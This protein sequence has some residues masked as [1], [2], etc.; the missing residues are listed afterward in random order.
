MKLEFNYQYPDIGKV[1]IHVRD[2]NFEWT[3]THRIFK[4]ETKISHSQNIKAFKNYSL[5]NLLNEL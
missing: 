2:T 3:V 5:N 4:H 1:F